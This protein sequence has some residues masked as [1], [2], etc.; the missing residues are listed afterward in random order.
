MDAAGICSRFGKV[1]KCE[2][3]AARQKGGNV[4]DWRDQRK[5]ISVMRAETGC[6]ARVRVIKRRVDFSCIGH[7]QRQM[8]RTIDRHH[9][10]PS[11]V[12]AAVEFRGSSALLLDPRQDAVGDNSRAGPEDLSESRSHFRPF[13]DPAQNPMQVQFGFQKR[14]LQ[15]VSQSRAANSGLRSRLALPETAKYGFQC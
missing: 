4:Q 11:G 12:A 3:N 7:S 10:D 5:P 9:S 15:F 13:H 1:R 8:T 14:S 2:I 6:D